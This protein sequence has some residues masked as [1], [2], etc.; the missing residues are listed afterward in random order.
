MLWLA[1]WQKGARHILDERRS[2]GCGED[3]RISYQRRGL[4]RRNLEAT[5]YE[6]IG[7]LVVRALAQ[8]FISCYA[9]LHDTYVHV[10]NPMRFSTS[11]LSKT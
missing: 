1:L 5:V 7:T 9:I 10:T 4:S 6:T 11:N 3:T 2:D 8:S